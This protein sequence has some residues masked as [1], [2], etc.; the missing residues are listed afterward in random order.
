MQ[1]GLREHPRYQNYVLDV[2]IS[3]GRLKHGLKESIYQTSSVG[4]KI[5]E[6]CDG[7][8]GMGVNKRDAVLISKWKTDE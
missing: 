6:L 1:L 3:D 5:T 7:K 4:N 2:I 8:G